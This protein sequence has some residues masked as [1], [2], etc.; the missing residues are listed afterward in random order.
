[1]SDLHEELED[2]YQEVSGSC[3][4]RAE[5]VVGID[6]AGGCLAGCCSR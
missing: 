4:T 6:A 3:A 1:M 2:I 5:W